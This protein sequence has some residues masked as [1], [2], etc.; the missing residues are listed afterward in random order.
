MEGLGLDGLG[1]GWQVQQARGASNG[2]NGC[3]RYSTGRHGVGGVV[4]T[5]GAEMGAKQE[6]M[7]QLGVRLGG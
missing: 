2:F 6:S 7:K 1:M 4:D 3:I 5:S